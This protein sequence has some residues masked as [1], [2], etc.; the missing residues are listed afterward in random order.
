MAVRTICDYFLGP[1]FALTN[2]CRVSRCTLN[3]PSTTVRPEAGLLCACKHSQQVVV[4]SATWL[5]SRPDPSAASSP[6]KQRDSSTCPSL[7][8][9]CSETTSKTFSFAVCQESVWFQSWSITTPDVVR[10]RA[11]NLQRDLFGALKPCGA[12]GLTAISNQ[13]RNWFPSLHGQQR[14]R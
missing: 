1:K 11:H 4:S 2:S 6:R 13:H 3:K 12:N 5:W 14:S 9:Y 7:Q 10:F 8:P